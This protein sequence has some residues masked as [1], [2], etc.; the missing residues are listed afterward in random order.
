M[1]LIIKIFLKCT[2]SKTSKEE[3]SHVSSFCFSLN[4]LLTKHFYLFMSVSLSSFPPNFFFNVVWWILWFQGLIFW[5]ISS[6]KLWY[7]LSNWCALFPLGYPVGVEIDPFGKLNFPFGL[8]SWICL[9]STFHRLM[10]R[11]SK[12]DY[13]ALGDILCLNFGQSSLII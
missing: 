4:C 7:Y 13:V 5:K 2:L 1:M 12:V 6:S 11:V 10:S 8:F 3:K 9:S